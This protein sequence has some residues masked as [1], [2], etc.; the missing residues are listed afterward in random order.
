MDTSLVTRLTAQFPKEPLDQQRNLLGGKSAAKGDRISWL[1]SHWRWPE[2]VRQPRVFNDCCRPNFCTNSTA[3]WFQV[4]VDPYG[5]SG[6]DRAFIFDHIGIQKFGK[7]LLTVLPFLTLK[8]YRHHQ[9]HQQAILLLGRKRDIWR[10][11]RYI[12]LVVFT[13]DS[14]MLRAS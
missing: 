8:H 6:V 11:V 9:Y 10:I 13:R 7:C 14:R 4:P 1:Q 5:K 3:W 2:Q 12:S